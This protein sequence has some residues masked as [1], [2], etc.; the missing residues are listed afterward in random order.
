[1]GF[2]DTLLGRTKP[3]PP[4][5]TTLYSVP[6]ATQAIEDAFGF[7]PTG[8][9]AV[10]F[11]TAEGADARGTS[12]GLLDLLDLEQ[13]TDSSI[14]RD[15]FGFTWAVC[16]RLDRDITMLMTQLHGVNGTLADAGFGPS[17]LCT[18]VGLA[19]E[20]RRLGLVYLCKRGTVYP[21]APT[22][23]HGRDT[24]LELQVRA[25]IAVCLPVESD[26]ERWFP[27]WDAPVP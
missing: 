1:M 14:V 9:G 27:L 6:V 25:A 21:F 16:H 7:E 26:V 8:M 5:L 17:L 19:R 20:E 23:H 18:V 24:E 2:L 11:R 13:G 12:Q 22:G 4:D 10:C 15:E 3:V